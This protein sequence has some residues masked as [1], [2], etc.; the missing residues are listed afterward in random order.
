MNQFSFNFHWSV[1]RIAHNL[2]NDIF[3]V[4]FFQETA[5]ILIRPPVNLIGNNLP[6]SRVQAIH[7]TNGDTVCIYIYIY[8][9]KPLI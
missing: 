2:A 1:L 7:L 5:F 4:I 8:I 9:V 6:L 3:N